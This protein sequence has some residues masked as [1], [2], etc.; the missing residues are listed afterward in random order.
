MSRAFMSIRRRSGMRRGSA[1]VSVVLMLVLLGPAGCDRGPGAESPGVEPAAA[2]RKRVPGYVAF[3]AAG[4]RDPL[5]PALR[6]SAQQ[7]DRTLCSIATQFLTPDGDSPKDQVDLL[8]SLTD[9]ALR[10]VCVQITDVAALEPVL[11]KLH[12]R[13]IRIVSMVQPAPLKWRV[14]HVGFD[15]LEVGGAL[16]DA[17]ADALGGHGTLMVL[18]AGTTHPAYGPRLRAFRERIARY[19]GIEVLAEV[20]CQGRSRRAREIIRER[21]ARYPRL[22]AWVA[23]DDWP[24]RGVSVAEEALPAGCKC[25]TFG[26]VPRHWP[27]VRTGVSPRIVAANYREMGARAL[28]FCEM[29][30]REVSRFKG[31]YHAPLRVIQPTNLDAY[32]ADWTRWCRPDGDELL[33]VPSVNPL[34]DVVHLPGE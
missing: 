1:G 31:S 17:V 19:P 23:L 28:Q 2:I 13:G 24:F 4:R 22:S 25:I 18:H 8:E 34:E 15:E 32:I 20:D 26:G 33:P 6:A 12:Q 11:R 29:A 3:V 30:I 10:G 21:F 16:A 7:Y 27:L 5:W 14:G 9:G